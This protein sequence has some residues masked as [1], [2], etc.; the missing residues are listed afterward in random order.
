MVEEYWGTLS[1]Y[2]HRDPVFLR[3]LLLFDRIVIPIPE[4]PFGTLTNQELDKLTRESEKLVKN[5]AA[6]IYKW[7]PNKFQEWEKETIREALMIQKNDKQ[8]HTRLQLLT[9]IDELKPKDVK[10]ISAAPVYGARKEFNEAYSKIALGQPDYLLLELSQLISVPEATGDK[11]QLDQII[12]LRDKE[13]FQS[14]RRALKNWQIEKM[15]NVLS[16]DSEKEILKAKEEFEIMLKRYE[17]E[18][19]KGKFKQT[20]V[21]VTSLLALGALFSAAMGQVTT[22]VA[23]LSGVVPNLFSL[24]ES[25][26]PA[27]KEIRDKNYEAAGVIYEANRIL[28]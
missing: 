21:I 18:I 1:I 26:I 15:P 27:W 5:N 11:F 6:V 10:Y 16:K 19:K 25:L 4:S 8:Y 28:A 9:Q 23:L 7:D 22:A 20:K 24:K 3:S 17:E 12:E 14:A 13:K 2:D